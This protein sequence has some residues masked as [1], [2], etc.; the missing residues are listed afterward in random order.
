MWLTEQCR[1][2]LKLMTVVPWWHN[3]LHL[4]GG[5]VILDVSL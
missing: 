3:A 5:V 2:M 4:P 1:T